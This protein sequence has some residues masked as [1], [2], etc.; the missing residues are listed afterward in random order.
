MKIII[1]CGQL[2]HDLLSETSEK[3]G[4]KH[5]KHQYRFHFVEQVVRIFSAS[6]SPV[7]CCYKYVIEIHK[8]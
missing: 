8:V 5:Y 6:F 4:S 2:S 7:F 1:K 3:D